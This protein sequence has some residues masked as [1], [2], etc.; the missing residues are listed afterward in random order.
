MAKFIRNKQDNALYRDWGYTLA[1]RI[2]TP[3]K[4]E[5]I[6]HWDEIEEVE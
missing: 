6:N 4:S 1:G 2:L 3:A 5:D